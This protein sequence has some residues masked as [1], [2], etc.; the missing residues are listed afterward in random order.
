MSLVNRPRRQ[1][2]PIVLNRRVRKDFVMLLGRE[3]PRSMLLVIKKD[4]SGLER[5][6]GNFTFMLRWP[7][8]LRRVGLIPRH[9]CPQKHVVRLLTT[10]NPTP[11][12][13]ESNVPGTQPRSESWLTRKVLASPSA[14]KVFKALTNILG[15]GRP[16]QV[17]GRRTLVLYQQLCAVRAEEEKDFWTNGK[18]YYLPS[19]Y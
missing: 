18:L 5:C 8:A 16:T 1:L 17:T 3:V 7:L 4:N 11:Q 14:F 15:Y 19:R 9:S 12:N 2:T 13:Q 6:R 10:S